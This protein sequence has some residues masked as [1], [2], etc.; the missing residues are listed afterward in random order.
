MFNYNPLANTNDGSCIAFV[1]GCTDPTM[2][3]YNPLANCDDNSCT[4]FIYGCTDNT[5]FNY[6]PLANTDNGSCEPFVYGCTDS[7]MFNYDPIANTDN[8]SC[9]AFIYGCTDSTAFNY[10]PLA[11]TLDNSCCY[12]SGCTDST[13]LNYN[14]NACYDDNTCIVAVIGCTDVSAYNYNPAANVSDST[15][16]LYDAG[17]YGGP[18]I[19][20]WL[21]DGCYA[22]VI[23]V[24]DYCCTT[25][26]DASCQSMYDYCQQGWPTSIQDISALGIVIYPN[27]TKDIITIETRLNIEIELYDVMGKKLIQEKDIKHLDLSHLSNGIYNLSIIHNGVRYSKKVIKQ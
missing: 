8:G 26:W 16:C 22:W 7:T 23:D 24:D 19:P 4:P 3:N 1:Y 12:I 25:N 2:F 20:Y 13:A 10:N 14:S 15:A 11:N 9:V 18:G 6:N 5:M 17:C 27:P 21:N